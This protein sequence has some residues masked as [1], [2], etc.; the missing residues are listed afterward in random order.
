MKI[1]LKECRDLLESHG[2]YDLDVEE[3]ENCDGITPELLKRCLLEAKPDSRF[4]VSFD[5]ESYN[6]EEDSWDVIGPGLDYGH[7]YYL[8]REEAEKVRDLLNGILRDKLGPNTRNVM[9]TPEAHAAACVL[10]GTPRCPVCGSVE[11]RIDEHKFTSVACI[12]RK[13]C[14]VCN[15]EWK[16]VYS[17]QGYQDLLIS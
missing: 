15:S 17:L 5:P 3:V 10:E 11:E 7:V 8:T 16:E 12:I 4:K 13:E 14:G 2:F 1:T 6:S 9:Y